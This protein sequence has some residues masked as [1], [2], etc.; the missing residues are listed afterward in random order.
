[1]TSSGS[2]A[3]SSGAPLRGLRVID[4]GQMIAVPLLGQWLGRLGA[5]VIL[6]ESRVN[7]PSRAFGPFA[8]KPG[9]NTSSIFNY[10]NR[11]KRSCTLNLRTARGVEL[12]KRLISLSDVVQENFSPGVM[13][14]LGLAYGD[15][16]AVKPDVTLLSLSAFGATGPWSRYAALHSGV[17]LLSGLAAVTGYADDRPRMVGSSLPDPIAAVYGLLAIT[18]ALRH[19]AVPGKGQHIDLAMT[20]TVQALLPDAIAECTVTGR[21]P[22][23]IGNGHRRKAPHGVYRAAGDDEWLALSVD[24]EAQWEALKKV[25]K[26][27][28]LVNEPGFSTEADRR[29]NHLALDD[30][31]QEWT[32]ERGAREAARTLQASGVPAAPIVNEP[33]LLD[34]PHLKERDFVVQDDHPEAGAHPMAG[35]PWRFRRASLEENRPAP[36]LGRD[37]DYVFRGILGLDSAEIAELEREQVIH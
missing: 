3:H 9:P 32:K 14:R 23:R 33:G 19:R 24:G 17:T 11:N 26:R 28:G 5:E 29:A 7:L 4:F 35:V 20:E 15:L 8:N 27:A 13:E 30:V 10:M 31:V 18:Q 37:N 25:I 21:E 2:P 34:D 1:M 16:A 6:V 22:P 12:A 36:T